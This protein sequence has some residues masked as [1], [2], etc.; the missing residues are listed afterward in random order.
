[1]AERVP[2]LEEGQDSQGLREGASGQE[3]QWGPRHQ[4]AVVCTPGFLGTPAAPKCPETPSKSRGA[5]EPLLIGVPM[6]G[7]L[8]PGQVVE[9]RRGAS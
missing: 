6:G 5:S 3:G 7:S 8:A 2:R 9:A 1:M 4:Q